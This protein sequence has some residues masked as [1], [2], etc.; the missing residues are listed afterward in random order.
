MITRELLEDALEQ[1][2]YAVTQAKNF[3]LTQFY[4]H[5][6]P[7][8]RKHAIHDIDIEA[9]SIIRAHLMPYKEDFGFR[10]EEQPERNRNPATEDHPFWLLDPNDGS[11]GFVEGVRGT[12]ISLALVDQSTCLPV[13]GIIWAYQMPND[14][15]DLLTWIQGDPC[16]KRNGIPWTVK[17]RDSLDRDAVIGNSAYADQKSGF[18]KALVHPSQYRKAVGIA[19]RLALVAMGECDV[20]CSISGTRDFDTAAGHALLIGQGFT[21]I[22]AQGDEIKYNPK[23]MT[24]EKFCFGGAKHL[25][26][27]MRLRLLESQSKASYFKDDLDIQQNP[28]VGMPNLL[29]QGE[30]LDQIQ[31]MFW[32]YAD[33]IGFNAFTQKIKYYRDLVKKQEKISIAVKDEFLDFYRQCKQKTDLS[34]GLDLLIQDLF[35]SYAQESRIEFHLQIQKGRRDIDPLKIRKMLSYR[36]GSKDQWTIDID[37]IAEYLWSLI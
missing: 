14:Q 37:L 11:S 10:G 4:Q 28:L 25:V 31:A 6:N 18:N 35:S 29:V 32:A 15:G 17:S 7:S 30:I 16:I 36:E 23:D 13:L 9:E 33:L 2:L 24:R 27:E 12:S 21:L 8:Q 20:S 34:D 1:A 3:L 22:N 26:E 19:Y 5:Q